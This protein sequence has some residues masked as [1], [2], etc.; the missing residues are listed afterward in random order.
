MSDSTRPRSHAHGYWQSLEEL[1][2]DEAFAQSLAREFSE[3]ASSPLDAVSRRGV[4]QLMSA[5]VALA[6]FAGCRWPVEEIVPFDRRPEGYQ[7]GKIARYATSLVV[8]GVAR[9]VVVSSYDGRPIKVEGN[10]EHPSSAGATDALTQAEILALYDPDRSR[11]PVHR[12]DGLVRRADWRE[13][14][15]AIPQ[16]VAEGPATRLAVLA[17]PHASATL[18]RVAGRLLDRF[19]AL[20]WYEFSAGHGDG[21]AEGLES[22]FGRPVTVSYDLHRARILLDFDADLLVTHP[23]AVANARGFTAGRHLP[24]DGHDASMNRLYCFEPLPSGTGAAADHRVPVAPSQ[25]VPALGSLAARL[26]A[27]G[28]L[29]RPE[30]L[31]G[32][33]SAG[34]GVNE[35]ETLRATLDAAADDLLSHQGAGLV[36][37][38]DRHPAAAH[39][40]AHRINVSLGNVALGDGT[41]DGESA[42]DEQAPVRIRPRPARR[43]PRGSLEALTARLDA[44]EIDCLL[45]LEGNP[46]FDAPPDL[47]L[48]SALA[49]SKRTVHL[50]AVAD[51]TANAC[52]WHLP[53]AHDLESWGDHWDRDGRLLAVQ[54]LIQPLFDGRTPAELLSMF[55][56][57]APRAAHA[58]VR[59]TFDALYQ[60]TEASPDKAWRRFLHDGFLAGTEVPDGA[61]GDAARPLEVSGPMDWEQLAPGASTAQGVELDLRPDSKVFDG[62]Y[63]N[64]GWLQELPDAITKLTW[65]NAALLGPSLAASLGV[66]HEDLVSIEAGGSELASE[67]IEL[68]VFV[69]PGMA[70]DTVSVALGYGRRVGRVAADVGVDAYGLQTAAERWTRR[71]VTVTPVGGKGALAS[72]QNHYAIDSRGRAERTRRIDRLV[73]EGTLEDYRHHPEFAQHMGLHH[74]PLVSLWTEREGEGHQWGMAIDLNSCIA[75]NACVVAC[76]AENNIPVVGKDEVIRG[77]EMHWLRI[78]RYFQGDPDEAGIAHQPMACA[79]CELAPCEQVCPVGATMHNA[80]GLNVMAYNRCVGTRYCANNCPYKVRR[81]NFFNYNEHV[82]DLEQLGKNPEVTIRARGVMEKCTYCVQRIEHARIEAKN[83]GRALRDG[84]V[85]T[86]CQQACS[87]DAITF[88]DLSDPESEVSAL[89]ADT[90]AY[91][92]LADLNIKPRTVYLARIRNPHPDLSAP[93]SAGSHGSHGAAHTEPEE[94]H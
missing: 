20:R 2:G 76:Q 65:G 29:A 35:P 40:L 25:I 6:S 28:R 16:L 83:D 50:G 69:L 24:A 88:G 48:A 5:S 85:V 70:R 43:V 47:E 87:T 14:E 12:A 9:P 15:A 67:A 74:P 90:R 57:E 10:P 3:S 54:P 56:D 39:A 63:G 8:A 52:Q 77:R 23:E 27:S 78:D 61:L 46:L 36:A 62:R 33:D 41:S 11:Q 32:F 58:M 4:L 64:N 51:E 18:E 84:D 55:A 80:E 38:G 26:V 75:C 44:G 86:A 31:A 81:F 19:P 71:G 34:M 93:S 45:I 79:H 91:A 21:E 73:R 13:F 68:P 49:Q 22:V 72:T 89:H 37:L 82:S 7:P 66:E 53:L 30:A 92:V 59:Q 17:R 42:A 60:G 1:A 94:V